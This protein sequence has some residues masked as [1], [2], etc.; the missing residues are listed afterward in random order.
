MST[1]IRERGIQ[2]PQIN[3]QG[4]DSSQASVTE[5]VSTFA[6]KTADVLADK[7]NKKYEL[8]FKNM[9]AEGI[10]A[11]YQRN[12]NNPLQLGKELKSLRSGL[13]KNAPSSMR[14]NFDAVFSDASRPYMNKATDGYG[15]I[16]TDQL[17]ESSL[18][19]MELNKQALGHSMSDLLSNDPVRRLDAQNSMQ[20]RIQDMTATASQT[21]A[22][23]MPIFSASQRFK[24]MQ[25]TMNDTVFHGIR[26]SYDNATDK[27]G[28]MNRLKSGDLKAS[29]FLNEKG[30]FAEMPIKDGMEI[31]MYERTLNYMEADIKSIQAEAARAD[32]KYMKDFMTDPFLIGG[33]DNV[34]INIANQI[35]QGV[36]P[37]NVRVMSNQAAAIRAN[38]L[39]GIRDTV[40]LQKELGQLKAEYGEQHYLTALEQMKKEGHLSE[41]TSF[42]AQVPLTTNKDI[43]DAAYMMSIDGKAITEKATGIDGITVNKIDEEVRIALADTSDALTSETDISR[44]AELEKNLVQVAIYKVA[45]GQNLN[46]AVKGATEWVGKKNPTGEYNNRRYSVADGY[47]PSQ[48]EP[49]LEDAIEATDFFNIASANTI[50]KRSVYPVLDRGGNRYYLKDPN[51]RAVKNKTGGIIYYP[52]AD[53]V[54]AKKAKTEAAR[55]KAAADINLDSLGD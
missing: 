44:T 3:I 24:M 15:K 55:A 13:I 39:N 10:D 25:D 45:N 4:I 42:V 34:D 12:Q 29:I 1:V 31:T 28:F 50:S 35:K 27:Q 22:T 19:S 14:E 54:N 7:A 30:E 5:Q 21:D 47:L 53:I 48:I 11:A 17:Q 6:L 37:G 8:D 41:L 40:S 36:A 38:Q 20:L 2:T 52:I 16:L 9:A 43:A 49:A 46:D 26:E 18:K 51:G 32:A 23:G 33:S